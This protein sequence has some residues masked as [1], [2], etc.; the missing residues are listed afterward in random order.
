MLRVLQSRDGS[1]VIAGDGGL[2]VRYKPFLACCR[3]GS[4]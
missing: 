3:Y 1:G 4:H 2:S